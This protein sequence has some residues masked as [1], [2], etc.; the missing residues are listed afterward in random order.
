MAPNTH[1]KMVKNKMNCLPVLG[2]S[3]ELQDNNIK[4]DEA[5]FSCTRLLQITI[6]KIVVQKSFKMCS[7]QNN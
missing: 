7:K 3:V 6:T 1:T 5:V 4:N 2:G